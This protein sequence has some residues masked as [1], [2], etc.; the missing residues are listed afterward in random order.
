M[1]PPQAFFS[2]TIH[3]V[4][5]SAMSATAP[6]VRVAPVRAGGYADGEQVMTNQAMNQVASSAAGASSVAAQGSAVGASGIDNTWRRRD[7]TMML[8]GAAKKMM[9]QIVNVL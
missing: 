5:P 9:E 1:T 2:L 3:R 7:N 8:F 6:P 4:Q